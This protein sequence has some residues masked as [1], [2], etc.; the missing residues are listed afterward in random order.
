MELLE[1]K[2]E[3]LTMLGVDQVEDV[4]DVVNSCSP[5]LVA[6]YRKRFRMDRDWIREFYQYYLADREGLKQDY[7]PPSLSKLLL[8]LVGPCKTLVDLCA[9]TG[10]LSLYADPGTK[11]KAI[12]L[13]PKAAACLRFNY[14]VHGLNAEVVQADAL[15][16][17]TDQTKADGAISNPP[18][19]IQPDG[20]WP[21]AKTGNWSFVLSALD[22]TTGRA[23]VI[24]PMGV[25]NETAD[26]TVVQNLIQRGQLKAVVKCPEKMF[27]STSIPVC[28]LVLSHEPADR[29]VLIDA[30]KLASKE[31]REQRGQYG[32][33]SHTGRVYKKEFSVFSDDAIERIVQA[34]NNAEKTDFSEPVPLENVLDNDCKLSPKMYISGQEEEPQ[35]SKLEWIAEQYNTIIRQKNAC[36]L[37]ISETFA[38][39]LGLDP[40]LWNQAK[41]NSAEVANAIQKVSGVKLEIEDYLTFTKSRELTIRFKSKDVLPEIFRQFVPMWINRVVLLN[42]LENSMLAEM[43][44]YLLPL[45]L[46]GELEVP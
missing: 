37:V 43:R 7:T 14:A 9:G 11:I 20:L 1:F 42:N 26:K 4:P 24:L 34:I 2:N 5:D 29:V 40:E 44:D 17:L 19:N 12:E 13:D 25:L 46:T 22:R 30:S 8:R 35:Q 41:K 6:R 21:P 45:L 3:F 27:L 28:V 38:K 18:F 33:T 32:G 23:A 31:V 15:T 16:F 39:E 36:K 10:S